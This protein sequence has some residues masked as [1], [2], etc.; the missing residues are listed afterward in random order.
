MI[1]WILWTVGCLLAAV[2]FARYFERQHR[3]RK[4]LRGVSERMPGSR[5]F[6]SFL[7]THKLRVPCD[8]FQG[9]LYCVDSLGK[10]RLTLIFPSPQNDA[11]YWV[12]C[13]GNRVSEEWSC[14]PIKLPRP[15]RY[16]VYTNS[17]EIFKQM[18]GDRGLW[19]LVEWLS[20]ENSKR[21]QL[22]V[23]HGLCSLMSDRKSMTSDSLILWVRNAVAL[24]EQIVVQANH[25]VL[26]LEKGESG[27]GEIKESVPRYHSVA[28]TTCGVCGQPI[29]NEQLVLC[30]KCQTPHH[31]DCWDFNGRCSTFGCGTSHTQ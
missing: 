3:I 21:S 29:P 17:I 8:V 2:C 28:N 13:S 15:T 9:E 30:A 16:P 19:D 10:K 24:F 6:S 25:E 26:F 12:V 4:L 7:L 14:E 23:S 20:D 18:L 5:V 11:L 31:R 1:S 22:E 27:K